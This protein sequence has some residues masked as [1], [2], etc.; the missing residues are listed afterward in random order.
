MTERAHCLARAECF[1]NIF[2]NPRSRFFPRAT[3]KGPEM[4][5]TESKAKTHLLQTLQWCVRAGL[6]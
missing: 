1:I 4:G 2:S 5:L 3:A 6:G